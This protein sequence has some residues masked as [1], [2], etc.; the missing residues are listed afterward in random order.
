MVAAQPAEASPGWDLIL[1]PDEPV[2]V[3]QD[4]QDGVTL[5]RV[6][7]AVVRNQAGRKVGIL[8]GRQELLETTLEGRAE[9]RR[10]RTLVFILKGYT[11]KPSFVD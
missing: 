11:Q 2:I 3:A 7:E 1:K 5:T 6:F 10:L 9:E 8:V 4:L